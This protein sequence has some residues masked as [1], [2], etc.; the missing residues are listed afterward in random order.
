MK[1]I[2]SIFW[3][4]LIIPPPSRGFWCHPEFEI[5]NITFGAKR[6]PLKTRKLSNNDKRYLHTQKFSI[7]KTTNKQNNNTNYLRSWKTIWKQQD[8]KIEQP[9]SDKS[10]FSSY[11]MY[12]YRTRVINLKLT[13]LDNATKVKWKVCLNSWLRRCQEKSKISLVKNIDGMPLQKTDT[14]W[15]LVSDKIY[16][17]HNLVFLGRMLLQKLR[18]D[19]H[20]R[21]HPTV[22]W[23]SK[24][25]IIKFW[26]KA[27]AFLNC[28][29]TFWFWPKSSE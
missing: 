26:S 5:R 25:N 2:E 28:N 11:Y 15:W 3:R 7:K 18:N 20:R 23:K 10:I 13:K 27:L 8:K 29:C 19:A 4:N 22:L 14:H 17:A 6:V 9:R 21:F 1:Y 16:D 24:T 12:C